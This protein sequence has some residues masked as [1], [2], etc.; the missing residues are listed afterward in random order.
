MTLMSFVTHGRA[1]TKSILPSVTSGLMGTNT[2]L[3]KWNYSHMPRTSMHRY[4]SSDPW[5]SNGKS[6]G[7]ID[8][9]PTLTQ[10]M[11]PAKLVLEDGTEFHGLGFGDQTST[12]GE[13]VFNTGM[14]GYPE[15]LTDPSYS[16]H[17]ICM[18]YPLIG[19]YGVPPDSVDQHGLV[20]SFESDKIHVKGLIVSDYSYEHSHWRATRSL[21]EWLK[22]HKVPGITG[23]D[24]RALTKHL[25]E[26]GVTLGKIVTNGNDGAFPFYDPTKEHLVA[27]VSSPEIKTYG[28]ETG[29][30]KILAVDCGMKT[31]IIRAMV[32][33]GAC[34]TVVPWDYDITSNIDDY[35]GLF[36]SNGPGDPTHCQTTIGHLKTLISR[37]SN[38]KPIFGI[39][40]G[41]QLLSLA[42]GCSYN[43]MLYGHRGHNQP[44]I[45]QI[46]GRCYITS[47][48][49]GYV[50]GN[51]SIKGE[52][53]PYFINANDGSN[54][55]IIHESKPFS[56]V[57]FHPEAKGGPEDTGFLFDNFLTNVR[58]ELPKPTLGNILVG[59]PDHRTE[60]QS[61]TIGNILV[62]GGDL[63]HC[64]ETFNHPL[65]V[66]EQKIPSLILSQQNKPKKVLILGSGGLQ[67]GQAG[68]FDYSGSQAVKA[69]KEEGIE[70]VLINPNI[71]TVQTAKGLADA[72]YFLPVLPDFVESVIE[73]ERPD[74]I[75][76]QFGG[77]TALNCGVEL[78][79]SGVLARNGVQVLGTSVETIMVT[80]D[81]ERFSTA[82]TEINEPIATSIA[83]STVE[84]ALAAADKIGF[85][86]IGRAAY[87]LGGLGSGF[88]N[89]KEELL[90][91][92]EK[93]FAVS[94]QVLIEKSLRGWKEVEYEVVRDAQDNCVTVC[95]MENFD[96]LGIHTGDSIVIA[97][98]QTLDDTEYHM[99]RTAAIRI[100]RHL[101]VVG[102]C[103][104][105]YALNPHSLEY[106]VIEVNPRLSRSSALASK[107]TGY[108]L[109]FIAA[110]LALGYSLPELRNSITEVT[111]ACFEP[112][113]DYV[114]CKI[115]RWD[116]QKFSKANN[117]LG[118]SMK[119]V[120]EVMA[121]GRTFEEAFQKALRMVD[122]SVQGFQSK[123]INNF[124]DILSKPTD[125]RVFAIAK[126]F[127]EGYT[128]E[129]LHQ[130]TRIDRWWLSKLFRIHNYSKEMSSMEL[131]DPDIASVLR[132][133][134]Q[135]GFSDI[136]IAQLM[137]GE[138]SEQEV[139]V[140]R[141]KHDI[142]P[143]FKQIDTVAA[144]WPSDTNY[145]YS[146]YH[147]VTNDVV[148]E[149]DPVVVLGAGC[150]CI[151]NSVEFDYTSVAAMRTIRAEGKKTVIIN[152]N[153]ETVSTDYDES[154][155]LYFEELSME[156]VMDIIDFESPEGVVVSVGGQIPNNLAMPL[157]KQGVH[158]IGTHPE[159]IDNAEDR[160]KFSS[161]CDAIGV[162]Q[163]AWEEL[164]TLSDAYTFADKVGYPVLVRPS[165]VLSGA[166]MRVVR[167]PSALELFLDQAAD[168][169][170]DHP[171]VISKYISGA[172]E[173]EFDGVGNKGE[174][175]VHAIHEHIEE[176]G[177]HSGDASLVMPP[178][179]LPAHLNA[180]V[181]DA[182]AKICK[183]LEITGPMN[184]QFIVNYA[185]DSVKVIE[186]NVRA[187]RSFP[188]VSKI[189]NV[190]FIQQAVRAMLNL[191]IDP[192]LKNLDLSKLN[193]V[194]V[195]V[196]NFS[197]ARLGGADPVLGVEMAS[198]G[199]VACFGRDKYEAFLK[200]MLARNFRLPTN[201]PILLMGD[202]QTNNM[203][204]VPYVSKLINMDYKVIATP[205]MADLLR[206]QGVEV[207]SVT[208]EDTIPLFKT[209]EVDL[210]INIPSPLTETADLA[211][212]EQHYQMRRCAVDFNIPV[213]ANLQVAQMLVESLARTERFDLR[214]QEDFV[215]P[216]DSE[217]G[218][219]QTK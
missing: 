201:K 45:D 204:F 12:S 76:L 211:E 184:C 43:K 63:R 193:F 89:N 112:S 82:L 109:A 2:V 216:Y 208:E 207:T 155:K 97:P 40:L 135:A 111:S 172:K 133:V 3:R 191:P 70:T 103:N 169:S 167:T 31:N 120:G 183:A 192:S 66:A 26:R 81:R 62:G 218:L 132:T 48:N 119:S 95:N 161:L 200:A 107:A 13:V 54:E 46:D 35:D 219:F 61:R 21:S 156:R 158:I 195:K 214:G 53:N 92:V 164:S 170:K 199:E 4:M 77:Q 136:K 194:G 104:V 94:P 32:S 154:D 168:V 51:E 145:L 121:I 174:V 157:H 144:E 105:Q 140:A 209:R 217:Q 25:R 87:A 175:I 100:V 10:A 118:S 202:N 9:V 60:N 50:I 138:L 150:Y 15:S 142:V 75:L 74:G 122:G 71:A 185:D 127:E 30:V 29:N 78:S 130:I 149:K 83:A 44:C 163:P 96:P 33:R 7:G 190:D 36:I 22:E 20:E 148:P 16:G 151:G 86:V 55:G 27:K 181:Y 98:S 84:E 18:T 215:H 93:S 153:P 85:P 141:K 182:A 106:C 39:C 137:K 160:Q 189:L 197:F 147:G 65:R 173:I 206:E 19:N 14:V 123:E 143:V 187:S 116:L 59:G 8:E 28:A 57:Q 213:I 129:E 188:F 205:G 162:D 80:E 177:V 42:A 152:H 126:A 38:V 67:I 117:Q 198:T 176:A 52:W 124:E 34:V 37:T 139:R 72:V 212:G 179:D 115:P 114:V 88:A 131:E 47:Q 1:R 64:I 79:E 110:K 134:K 186:C 171:V 58:R 102:E 178:D 49:H 24:T 73:K 196:P 69:L 11:M 165:Y 166:A 5:K 6:H 23:I 203:A 146:T 17:I 101:G 99:L 108:P 56:S 180:K 113:L 210:L 90:T 125:Q 41:H 68:E 159:K 128:V 91:L